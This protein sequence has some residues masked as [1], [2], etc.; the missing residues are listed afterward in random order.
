MKIEF[1]SLNQIKKLS[2]AQYNYQ[3]CIEDN[4]IY[5]EVLLI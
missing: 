4:I 1:T 5:N 3:F 2:D